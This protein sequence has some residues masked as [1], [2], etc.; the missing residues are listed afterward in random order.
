M[1]TSIIP[2]LIRKDFMISRTMVGVFCLVSLAGVAAIGLL[3]GRVP[4]WAL[5][6]IAF[7]LLMSPAA[8]CGMVLLMTTVV[9]EREKSTQAFIMSLPVTPKQFI[10]AKLLINI[11]VFGAFWL[12]ISGV[13]LFFA[14]GRGFFPAGMFPIRRHGAA[15]G[16]RGLHRHPQCRA[17]GVSRW[18]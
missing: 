5:V 9:F 10:F 2:Q 13:A 1:T 15:G 16:V 14:F 18:A 7:L 17:C 12:A 8:T 4:G 6:N 3:F 11:G